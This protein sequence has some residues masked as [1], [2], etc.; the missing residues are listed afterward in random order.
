MALINQSKRWKTFKCTENTQRI[1]KERKNVNVCALSSAKWLCSFVAR[2]RSRGKMTHLESRCTQWLL[3]VVKMLVALNNICN[4]YVINE[5]QQRKCCL[6]LLEAETYWCS[7]LKGR[8]R[9]KTQG[10]LMLLLPVVRL[11]YVVDRLLLLLVYIY[12]KT[13]RQPNGSK[14]KVTNV[15]EIPSRK[16]RK[17]D[18]KK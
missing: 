14:N 6:Y 15:N 12:A 9:H 8:W 16:Q 1:E 17:K 3:L 18:K 5:W 11:L 7:Q 13:Q 4:K 10:L 2:R